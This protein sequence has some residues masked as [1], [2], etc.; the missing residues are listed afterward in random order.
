[1]SAASSRFNVAARGA[2]FQTQTL[3]PFDRGGCDV[4]GLRPGEH[5]GEFRQADLFQVR[6]ALS[7]VV[8]VVVDDEVFEIVERDLVGED[9]FAVQRIGDGLFRNSIA[10]DRFPYAV[11]SRIVRAPTTYSMYQL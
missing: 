7:P 4:D 8:P 5:I 6:E 3:I 10:S 9:D 11:A 1:L 2:V